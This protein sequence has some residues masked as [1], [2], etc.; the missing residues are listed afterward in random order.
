VIQQANDAYT[1]GL[2]EKFIVSFDQ[3]AT[4]GTQVA[5]FTTFAQGEANFEQRVLSEARDFAPD[6]VLL[7]VFSQDGAAIIRASDGISWTGGATPRWM[8]PD[9]LRDDSLI[10]KV[11]DNTL[12]EGVLGT[13]PAAPRGDDYGHFLARHTE[14]FGGQPGVYAA[15]A[16][17]GVYLLAGAMTVASDPTDG[18]A[19]RDALPKT[20]KAAGASVFHAGDW[21]GFSAALAASLIADYEGA[22]GNV[23]FDENG[24]VQSSI[25]EWTI[26]NGVIV[27][28]DNDCWEPAGIPCP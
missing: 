20:Q 4:A 11:N 5:A 6:A 27:D 25:A 16:Y 23:D 8:M 19:L 21:S 1:E 3:S 15:N 18:L 24:D 26:E 10:T 2:R 13:S 9:S 12:I 28:A 14:L 7:S 22:S 17:D